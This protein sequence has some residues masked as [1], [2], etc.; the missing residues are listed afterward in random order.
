[1]NKPI[2]S[3]LIANRGEIAVRIAATCRAMGIWVV[4]VY[5]EYDK[6]LPHA[7]VA[8]ESHALG[9]G[10]LADTYLNQEKLIAIAK[11]AGVDA[12]HPGYG[13]LSENAE[14]AKRV[15]EAGLIFIGPSV[16]C[17]ADMGDKI[18]ARAAAEKA[19]VS[20]VPGYDGHDQSEKTLLKEASRI[21]YP[22][23]VKASAGGGGK[24]MRIVEC[25]AEFVTALSQ[26]KSE[27]QNAFGDDR[28]FLEKYIVSPRHIE[29]QVFSDMHGNHVHLFERECSIQRR[30][31]KIIEE[32]PSPAVTDAV[33]AKVTD[34]AVALA[35]QIG[36]VGAG[37]V[38]FIMDRDSNLYFLEMNTRLQVEHPVT[39]MVTGLDLVRLQILV[40]QGEKL[41][42]TQEDVTQRG[43]AIECRIYAENPDQGHLPVTGTLAH[44][45]WV[46]MRNVRVD[47]GYA[48][49]NEVTMH[50][51]P[52]IAKVVAWGETR[53][54]AI[55][56]MCSA[57]SDLTF[58]GVKTNRAYLKRILQ[59]EAFECGETFTNF[60]ETH[61]GALGEDAVSSDVKA[62]AVAAFLL[63][64]RR[65]SRTEG[66]DA[67][68]VS[69][70]D[71][72]TL[73]GFRSA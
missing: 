66:G 26:A 33:R 64:G 57:L 41:P 2:H 73:T 6:E 22:V 13:F 15:E 49:G 8:D 28:V 40:A 4:T 21:G 58:A 60:L 38:E 53:C 62:A 30:H 3:I 17:I 34:E 11:Q 71:G 35:R 10:T 51:D 43:H 19:R 44:I 12:V 31:Q 36:Y 23:M 32:T 9:E 68:V 61:E 5:S 18:A 54:D 25:E 59:H 27:A 52:M 48:A 20:V 63:A 50:Y 55:A 39:E 65:S 42:F 46:R 37:T 70:W 72:G 56:T 24:G 45:G 7:L 47:S 67:A 69:V 16:K 14:F 29:V 1:M